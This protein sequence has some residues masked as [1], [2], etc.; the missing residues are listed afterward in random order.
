MLGGVNM[1]EAQIYIKK[2]FKKWKN[3]KIGECRLPVF[4]PLGGVPV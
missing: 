4:T 1:L 3:E 2:H